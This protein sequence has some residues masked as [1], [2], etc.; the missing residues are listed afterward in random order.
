MGLGYVEG[1][2]LNINDSNVF[3]DIRVVF[4][5]TFDDGD[6]FWFGIGISCCGTC[7]KKSDSFAVLDSSP[8]SS[9]VYFLIVF[10]FVHHL[11][12][13]VSSWFLGSVKYRNK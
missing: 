3:E 10:T 12:E 2:A 5:S 1:S 8:K 9:L 13:Y 4:V 6:W 11:R 7:V